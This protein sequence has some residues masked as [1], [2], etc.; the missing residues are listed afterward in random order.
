MDKNNARTALATAVRL[1]AI[2][3]GLCGTACAA[4]PP[5]G[6]IDARARDVVIAAVVGQLERAYVF[7]DKGKAM[8]ADLRARRQHGEFDGVAGASAFAEVLTKVLR[9]NSHDGHLEVRYMPLAADGAAAAAGVQG[10]DA[11][12]RIEERRFNFGVSDVQR[13]KGNIGYI[14]VHQFGRPDGAVPRIAAAMA[15]VADTA[16]L[17]VDLRQ[18]SGGDPETV[19]AFASYLYDKPT[20][21]NDVYWRD[22]GRLERRWTSATVAGRRYGQSRPVYLLT[23]SDTFSGCEDLAY[24]LKNNRRAVLVGEAT[25][26][27]AHAGSPQRLTPQFMMFVPT[28]RPINPVTH[29]DWEGVGVAPDVAVSA[30]KAL[31]TAQ[32][33]AL[34]AMIAKESDPLWKVK[35]Q[36]RL[37]QLD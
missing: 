8:A 2:G 17:V 36:K 35:L 14:D 32:V 7:P 20:H 9:E 12:E 19:M 6:P 24:A 30:D 28:G 33:A 27:G 37:D 3:I 10:V 16:T 25:G 23:S 1:C 29:T 13:L 22:D 5:D 26:G 34:T 18:C 31:D 4:Q 11:D 21:L 15:L